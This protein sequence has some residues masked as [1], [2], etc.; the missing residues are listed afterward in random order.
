[1][2][3]D[4]TAMAHDGAVGERTLAILRTVTGDHDL[5]NDLDVPL[6]TSGLLDSLGVV[7]L[8]VALEE[9]FGLVISPAEL[10]REAWS[11]ARSLVADIERRVGEGGSA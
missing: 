10:D 2:R 3:R 11:T 1:M 7:T 4:D 6:F 5:V 8:M 9:A